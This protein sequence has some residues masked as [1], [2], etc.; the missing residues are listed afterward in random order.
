HGPKGPLGFTSTQ[1]SFLSSLFEPVFSNVLPL[2]FIISS[3]TSFFLF[4]ENALEVRCEYLH[5][6]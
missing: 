3:Y 2:R 6:F 1:C 5:H 4:F